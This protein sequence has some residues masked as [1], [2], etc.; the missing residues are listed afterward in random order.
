MVGLHVL[1]RRV[2]TS[3]T[4]LQ[5]AFPQLQPQS[6]PPHPSV[7]PLKGDE[8]LGFSVLPQKI[9]SSPVTSIGCLLSQLR[10]LSLCDL[11]STLNKLFSLL[12]IHLQLAVKTR[13]APSSAVI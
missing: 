10:R 5:S 9:N 13:F 4:R 11:T 6:S 1:D 7:L 3:T 8:I 2:F 12:T